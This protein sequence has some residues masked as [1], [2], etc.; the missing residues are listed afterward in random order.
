MRGFRPHLS[1]IRDIIRSRQ[2]PVSLIYGRYDRIIRWERGEKFRK[3]GI[4]DYCH[5]TLLPTGHQVLQAQY[6]DVL[7]SALKEGGGLSAGPGANTHR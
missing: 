5:L 6:L 3:K 2:V 7:L 1:V 4:A